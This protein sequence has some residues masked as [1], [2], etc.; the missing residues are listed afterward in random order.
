MSGSGNT[1][2]GF[3]QGSWGGNNSLPWGGFVPDIPIN[4]S[5]KIKGYKAILDF[6]LPNVPNGYKAIVPSIE[7]FSNPDGI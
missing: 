7:G 1:P 6:N 3:G 2:K 4:E 5:L